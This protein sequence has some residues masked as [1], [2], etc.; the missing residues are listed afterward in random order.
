M[1]FT[2]RDVPGKKMLIVN[3]Q[4]HRNRSQL[5]DT[6]LDNN[7]RYLELPSHGMQLN[8]LY[9]YFLGIKDT[10]RKTKFESV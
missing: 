4:P 6:I 9:P 7:W 3:V 5:Q 1:I 8:P 2:Q 10:I